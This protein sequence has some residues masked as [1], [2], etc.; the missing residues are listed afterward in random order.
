[1]K[2][3]N[4]D[5]AYCKIKDIKISGLKAYVTL[6]IYSSVP[7]T[8]ADSLGN[9][10]RVF[11]FYLRDKGSTKLYSLS[12]NNYWVDRNHNYSMDL[13]NID[14]NMYKEII[15]EIDISNY[16]QGD[17]L[18]TK[19]VRHCNIIILNSL[20]SSEELWSSEELTLISKEIVLP[21]I[22][23]IHTQNDQGYITVSFNCSYKTQEDFNYNNS[24][25]KYKIKIL[26]PNTNFI[27]EEQELLLT[28]SDFIN[29]H[30]VIVSVSEKT[31]FSPIVVCIEILN[32]KEE[33]LK[34]F[35]TF[36]NPIIAQPKISVV[37]NTPLKSKEACVYNS[38]SSSII[39]INI[40]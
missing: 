24:N 16:G 11:S 6:V 1:M 34:Y 7:Q 25:I 23:N 37:S 26:E 13:S 27:Y 33:V 10:H 35:K 21:D 38:T 22:T 28:K 29:L 8:S 39:K 12:K 36:M 32:I 5:G 20:D 3:K 18:N 19:W 40:I 15:L 14:I 2:I 4:T 31:Y 17:M 9:T 30:P